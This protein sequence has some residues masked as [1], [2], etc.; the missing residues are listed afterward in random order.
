MLSHEL[1]NISMVY[2]M[3]VLVYSTIENSKQYPDAHILT[4]RNRLRR[5]VSN[6]YGQALAMVTVNMTSRSIELSIHTRDRERNSH[7][8][9]KEQQ[10]F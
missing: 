2:I 1:M 10:C 8:L 6:L 3:C 4:Q 9:D 7:P 5:I